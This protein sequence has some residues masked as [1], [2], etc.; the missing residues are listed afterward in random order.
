LRCRS[1]LSGMFRVF[2][3]GDSMIAS[4]PALE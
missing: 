1:W 4:R 2:H 3:H